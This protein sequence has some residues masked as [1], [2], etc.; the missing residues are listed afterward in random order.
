M[1]WDGVGWGGVGRGGDHSMCLC[2][3]NLRVHVNS[4][5]LNVRKVAERNRPNCGLV[6]FVCVG[7]TNMNARFSNQMAWTDAALL[8]QFA[9]LCIVDS[10]AF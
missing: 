5:W 10:M 2:A 1:G 9:F 6:F 4:S 8:F 3:S 7:A